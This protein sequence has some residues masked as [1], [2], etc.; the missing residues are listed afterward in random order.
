MMDELQ[1]AQDAVGR[2]RELNAATMNEIEQM[3]GG[4]EVSIARI[5]HFIRWICIHLDIPE[6][7]RWEEQLEWEKAL[8]P[9]LIGIRDQLKAL[10]KEQALQMQAQQSKAP[11]AQQAK[12][13]RLWTP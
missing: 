5:E 9:Q 10:R 2:I 1:K 3:G 13:P 6:E 4:A 7:K 12:G 8:K 11:G